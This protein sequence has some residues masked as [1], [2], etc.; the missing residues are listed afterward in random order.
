MVFRITRERGKITQIKTAYKMQ[1]L[2]N[3]DM[4]QKGIISFV[5]NLAGQEVNTIYHKI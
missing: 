3:S 1:F 2:W 4:N 5:R